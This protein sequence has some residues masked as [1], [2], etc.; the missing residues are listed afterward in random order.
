[1]ATAG[2]ATLRPATNLFNL[3]DSYFHLLMYDYQ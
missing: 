1:M 2:H 3:L